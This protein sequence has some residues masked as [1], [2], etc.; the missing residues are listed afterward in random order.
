MRDLIEQEL[1]GPSVFKDQSKLSFDYV[2]DELPGREEEAGQLAQA[3]RGLLSARV[4][5]NVTITGPVG[6]GKTALSK[7]FCMEFHRAAE[8]R[9]TR[10]EWTEVNGRKKPSAS[11]ALLKILQHFEPRFPDRGFSV[12]EML[13][14]LRAQL[15]RREAHLIVV[16]DEADFFVKRAGSELIYD[17]T[18]FNEDGSGGTVSLLLTGQQHPRA[19]LDEASA[20]TLKIAA[21]I[22][23][24]RYGA[25]PL[26]RI[27]R[28]RVGLAFHPSTVP[29][30]LPELLGEIAAEFG[31][32]SARY[33]IELLEKAGI[34][35]DGEGRSR[36]NAEDV[37]VAKAETYGVVS[38]AKLRDLDR[39]RQL[40]LLAV[41]RALKRGDAFVTTGE[42]EKR[43]AL[44]C[45]EHGEAP[46]A[47]TQ[48]WN[49]LKDLEAAGLLTARR[50]GKGMTGAT[51][52]LSLPD[53]PARVLEEKMLE[54]LGKRGS[55]GLTTEP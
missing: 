24:A 6:V 16:L 1:H 29:D 5:V 8:K 2:P 9:G 18:R 36:L 12:S 7:R 47:H 14:N 48:Y 22:A 40:A 43:Y 31:Q 26:S 23:L 45:E 28:Q 11:A 19:A 3:F 34:V 49:Y 21:E 39:H 42:A 32:G 30:D 37:R 51:T 55:D 10:V 53:V 15:A 44:A 20:S 25:E 41:A 4:P 50:S 17:L 54:I 46:R 35:A 38:E 33:A 52:L 27:V 13:D